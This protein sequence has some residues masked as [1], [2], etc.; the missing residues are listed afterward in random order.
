M[1]WN[2]CYIVFEK[3]CPG[4]MRLQ[5]HKIRFFF[6]ATIII[7]KKVVNAPIYLFCY[8]SH[9]K[10]H[11]KSIGANGMSQTVRYFHNKLFLKQP[12]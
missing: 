9:A 11:Y 3:K 12:I 5:M 4:C 8:L 6:F 2:K 1:F 7:N 10:T